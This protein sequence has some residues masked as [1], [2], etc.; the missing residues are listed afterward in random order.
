MK[1]SAMIIFSVLTATTSMSFGATLNS[2]DKDQ[3]KQAFVNK[4]FTSVTMARVDDQAITNIFI[5]SMD[6]QGKIYGKFAHQ[7]SQGPQRD[8]GIYTIKDNGQLCITWQHWQEKKESCFYTY[9]TD[10]AYILVD[11]NDR[12]H[13]LFMKN[14][15]K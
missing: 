6:A 10:N 2:I 11:V 12:F 1:K 5:G 7:P 15:I 13:I 9:N 8:Q 3:V 4:T 14:D